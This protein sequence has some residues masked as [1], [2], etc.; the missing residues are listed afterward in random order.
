MSDIDACAAWAQTARD[1]VGM[2]AALI[3]ACGVYRLV[4]LTMRME[5]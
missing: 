5:S 3:V 4:V 2:I 1:I